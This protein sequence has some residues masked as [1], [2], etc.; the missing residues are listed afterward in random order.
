MFKFISKK[1]IANIIEYEISSIQN[2]IDYHRSNDTTTIEELLDRQ[3]L[4]RKIE[5]ILLS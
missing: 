1:K 5:N 3:H 4:L 2:D